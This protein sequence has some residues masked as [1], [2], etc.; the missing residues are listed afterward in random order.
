MSVTQLDRPAPP[1]L[2]LAPGEYAS[3]YQ[4]QLN[5]VHRLYYNRLNELLNNL[6]I[7]N[8]GRYIGFPSGAFLDTTDQTAASTTAAY[9][10]S[11]NTTDYSN[12]VA[13][14]VSDNTKIRVTHYGVYNIQFSIQFASTDVQIQD[15]DVWLRKGSGA[16]AASDVANSNSRFSVPN[17]HGGVDGHVIAA[18]NIFVDLEPD[19]Y[20]QLMWCTT[21]TNVSVQHINAASSPTRPA[22]PSVILT[23]AFVSR[24]I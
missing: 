11:F 12:D 15:V 6:L 9:A 14:D 17:S 10:L 19:D 24:P 7:D 3:R 22:T 23:A 4:E 5:N 16:G 21:S 8:G 20:I 1:N 18:L 13:R 2:P